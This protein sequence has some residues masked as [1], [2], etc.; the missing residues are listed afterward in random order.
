MNEEESG[1]VFGGLGEAAESAWEA[2]SDVVDA[3]AHAAWGA[4]NFIGSGE[5][6]L[7]AGA[8]YAVGEYETAAEW[9]A[10]ARSMTQTAGDEFSAAG[11]SASEAYTDVV[12]E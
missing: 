3:G 12:G 7:A 4:A 6:G 2:A 11:D 1:S 10:D 5:A 8:A 9:D